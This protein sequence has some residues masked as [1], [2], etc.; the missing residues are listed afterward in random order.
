VLFSILYPLSSTLHILAL[1]GLCGKR[2]LAVALPLHTGD[3]PRLARPVWLAQDALEHF[4]GWRARQRIHKVH[5]VRPLETRQLAASPTPLSA[6]SGPHIYLPLIRKEGTTPP[7]GGGQPEILATFF[8]PNNPSGST[9]RTGNPSIAVDAQGGVH[10]VYA[11]LNPGHSDRRPAYHAYCPANCTSA[12]S[13]RTVGLG[14][15][16]SWA[17]LALDAQGRPHVLLD[18]QPPNQPVIYAYAARDVDCTNAANWTL[19]PIVQAQGALGIARDPHETFALDA[20]GRP[21]FVYY[22]DL[23]GADAATSGTFFVWCDSNCTDSQQWLQ[24]KRSDAYWMSPALAIAPNGEPRIAFSSTTRIFRV[25]SGMSNATRPA[26]TGAA[27]RWPQ[28]VRTITIP[29]ASSPS[30]SRATV[31][32]GWRSSPGRHIARR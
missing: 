17:E 6:Q 8:L 12:A 22:S 1:C 31:G 23:F 15:M 19:T 20:Q 30:G 25:S 27:L 9:V 14:D 16:M 32:R 3:A 2:N 29:A 5:R 4:A 26:R 10:A 28:P 21:R 13:F 7:P 11:A 18:I 24:I